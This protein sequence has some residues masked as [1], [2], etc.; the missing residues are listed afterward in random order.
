MIKII[1]IK[2]YD[3]FI[4]VGSQRS[5]VGSRQ[6]AVGS[7]RST[8]GDRQS[9]IGTFHLFLVIPRD[10]VTCHACFFALL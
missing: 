10:P 2:K 7:Q 3:W 6:S 5:V 4:V 1:K 8:V 9:A